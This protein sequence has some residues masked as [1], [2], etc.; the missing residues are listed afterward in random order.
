ML[1]PEKSESQFLQGMF[2]MEQIG[3]QKLHS[4][5]RVLNLNIYRLLFKQNKLV[6]QT[7]LKVTHHK[8]VLGPF[9]L[10]WREVKWRWNWEAR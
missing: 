8:D 9:A 2:M 5:Y 6:L 3:T 1:L 4:Y 10:R 7:V